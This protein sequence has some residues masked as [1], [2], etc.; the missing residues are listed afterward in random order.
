MPHQ[1]R[2]LYLPRP[3]QA[4]NM[5][6]MFRGQPCT[7][8]TSRHRPNLA[9]RLRIQQTCTTSASLYK[10]GGAGV[11]LIQLV[12]RRPNSPGVV[13]CASIIGVTP[14]LFSAVMRSVPN[15]GRVDSRH[16]KI[17]TGMNQRYSPFVV[18]Y[19]FS[20][21]SRIKHKPGVPCT[22]DECERIFSRVDNMKDHVRRIHQKA[23]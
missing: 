9:Q 19:L 14:N 21:T 18:E 1:L 16:A 12:I 4:T 2:M 23:S 22:H 15:Q 13:I 7:Q 11:V 20:L 8:T 5:G 10:M 6:R 17:E 3:I